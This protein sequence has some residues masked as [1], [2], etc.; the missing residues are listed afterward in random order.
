VETYKYKAISRDGAKVSGVVEAFDE[1]AAVARIKETCSV[2]TGIVRV[3]DRA[4]GQKDWTL[5]KI[6]E[7]SLAVMCSQFAIILSAGL[8]IVRTVELIADQTSDKALKRIL[9]QAA[10][11]VAAGFGLAQ[12]FENKGK[13]LPATFIE[14]V[15][16]GEE[17]GTLDTAFE[18]LHAYYDKSSKL[19]GKVTAAMT[20]PLFTIVVAIA[21]IAVI[22]VKAVPTFVSSFASMG[23]A[24]PAPTR[25]LIAMS[26][27]FTRYWA[28]LAML[29]AGGVIVWKF[30][31]RTE[32]GRL[33]QH[34]RKLKIPVL[35]KLNRMKAASQ[36]ANTMSTLL[37]A[38]LPM[39]RSVHITARV[40]DNYWIGSEISRQLPKLEEGKTLGSCLKSADVLPELLTE[41]AA[42][43]EETGTMES[44][45]DVIGVYYDNETELLSQ[46]ALSLLE[47]IVICILAAFVVFI[48]LS[49]YLPMFSL[50]GNLAG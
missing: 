5:G 3:Q 45:L 9:Q 28:L 23:I 6:S 2:V 22:M 24:L 17:S 10:S 35:G 31:G 39:V 1:Y 44:T 50:Y 14:T 20:Y 30:W 13:N 38:G 19:R 41:M 16:S 37:S 43:G 26:G 11:D 36:F 42:V 40:L 34:R 8:P 15:R 32:R 46:R 4:E 49:V 7:K 29:V 47:P 25:A 21:V 18:K 27:F 33:W 12:S 48:L